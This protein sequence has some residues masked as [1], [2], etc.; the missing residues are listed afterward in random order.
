M[1]TSTSFTSSQVRLLDSDF[2]PDAQRLMT[3]ADGSTILITVEPATCVKT[4]I[5]AT[6]DDCVSHQLPGF[7]KHEHS[8]ARH[9]ITL[10]DL[11]DGNNTTSDLIF[12]A[13]APHLNPNRRRSKVE[14]WPSK[15]IDEPFVIAGTLRPRQ[16]LRPGRWLPNPS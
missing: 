9:R 11:W 3:L 16:H 13:S 12:A 2:R 15:G 10:V 8:N 6:L 14:L 1:I 4:Q 7:L 5:I